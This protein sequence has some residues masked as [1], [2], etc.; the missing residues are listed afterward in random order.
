MPMTPLM[1]GWGRRRLSRAPGDRRAASVE[2][3]AV[4]LLAVREHSR[5]EMRRK[6]AVRCSDQ[7]LVERCSM[8]SSGGNT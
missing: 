7:G 4:R 5:Q 3:A 1:S 2:A 6:L 8:T